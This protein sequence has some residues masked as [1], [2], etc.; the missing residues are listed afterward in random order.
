MVDPE[1]RCSD[2]AYSRRHGHHAD[3]HRTV[4]A[5]SR[6]QT[7]AHRDCP[8][9]LGCWMD[10]AGHQRLDAAVLRRQQQAIHGGKLWPISRC[11][12]ERRSE[13]PFRI[14]TGFGPTIHPSQGTFLPP[15]ENF[16]VPPGAWPPISDGAADQP[17]CMDPCGP[18]TPWLVSG[19][20]QQ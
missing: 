18:I 1:R 11:G 3:C 8:H 16:L 15:R 2:P 12:S 4:V 19:P 13:Q 20:R 9:H 14:A 10:G 7:M 5:L 17:R 6:T